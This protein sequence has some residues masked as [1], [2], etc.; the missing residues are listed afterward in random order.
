M[1][2]SSLYNQVA[3]Y[4][5]LEKRINIAIGKKS[6][7]EY[8]GIARDAIESGGKYF[9]DIA[10]IDTLHSNME[11]NCIPEEIFEMEAA[12]YEDFLVQRRRLMAK[13]IELYFKSL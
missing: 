3:N 2:S 7:K 5:F 4:A 8:F 10:D 6:P 11:A 1:G 12:D 9:G 13:K